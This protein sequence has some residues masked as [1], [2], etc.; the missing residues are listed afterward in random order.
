MTHLDPVC[1]MTIEEAEA[2]G[3]YTHDG[4]TYYFCHP[5]CLD[6]FKAD[7]KQFLEP[8]PAAQ[9]APGAT[10]TCPMHPEI[11]QQGPGSCP[12]CGMALEPT[13]VSLADEPNPELL[14]MTRRFRIAAVLAAPV[15]V[16][17]M[18]DMA[19]GGGVA[20]T[21]V[22]L[23]SGTGF[24]LSTPVVFWAGW[25]FFE[26][27]WASVVNRS[28]NMFTLIALGVGAAYGT[29][30]SQPSRPGSFR[31]GSGCTASS[32]PISTPRR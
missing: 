27:A 4:V 9:A 28:P 13:T 26:R 1:G 5:S 31:K 6:R 19:F 29:V 7:P 17:T 3:T 15:F 18:A 14:D 11:V 32:K 21:R 24:A 30:R 12:I 22:P 23:I 2:V 20:M 8:A 25:P 10:Y 16:V